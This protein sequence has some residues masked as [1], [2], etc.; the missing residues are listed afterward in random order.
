MYLNKWILFRKIDA[1][2]KSISLK[3]GKNLAFSS[4]VFFEVKGMCT[5]TCSQDYSFSINSLHTTHL[6]YLLK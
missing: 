4:F 6:I 5:G 2:I 1:K 3:G